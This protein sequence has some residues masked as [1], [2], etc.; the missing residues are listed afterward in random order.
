MLLNLSNHPTN[1][2]SEKQFSAAIEKYKKVEDMAF[3]E[4]SPTALSSD[5]ALLVEEYEQKIRK[6]DPLAVHIAGELT[7]TFRLVNK[8]KEIGYPCI[9]STSHRLVSQEGNKKTIVFEFVQ[10][11]SY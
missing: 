9:A 1:D 2:W 10:F 4:I 3:P 6:I 7:F 5:L 11:R 8:L